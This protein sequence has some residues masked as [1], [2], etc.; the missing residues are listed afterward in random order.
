[1]AGS[2][3]KQKL[4]SQN[5]L[6]RLLRIYSRSLRQNP[7]SIET[8][9]KLAEVLRLLGRQEEAISLYRSVAWAYGLAGNL[10]QAISVCKNILQL[11]PSHDQTQN[12]LAKLYACKEIRQLKRSVHVKQVDGRWVAD[13]SAPKAEPDSQEQIISPPLV[14]S[15]VESPSFRAL[16]PP[17]APSQVKK[18][19]RD[20]GDVEQP[21]SACA[22][23]LDR[24][25]VSSVLRM[26]AARQQQKSLDESSRGYAAI[27]QEVL[28]TG[29]SLEDSDIPSDEAA[30][31]EK[32]LRDTLVDF[33]GDL[34]HEA[35]PLRS[36]AQVEPDQPIPF[37]L[38]SDMDSAAFV[39]L[40]E[41]LE[42]RFYRADSLV[43]AENDPGDS[44]FL[45]SDGS[46]E[47]LKEN[48]DGES[49]IL[50]TLETGAF[51]GEFGLLT[52]Q[53]RHATVRALV[54]TELLELRR[55]VLLELIQ[56]HPSVA[57]TLRLFYQQR[58]MAMVLATSPLFLAVDPAERRTVLSRF[59]VRRFL[60]GETI[61]EMGKVTSG[62]YVILVGEVSVYHMDH[63]GQ[64]VPL[65]VLSEG[66]YFGEMSLLS[67][68]VAGATVKASRLTEVLMLGA[69]DFYELASHHPEIWAEV[70][71]QAKRRQAQTAEI[72]AVD[73]AKK[74]AGPVCLL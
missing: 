40:V 74:A 9:Y 12:M 69:K 14:A 72:L 59:A 60:Q 39:A 71:H 48:D 2:L 61:I 19:T 26:D 56:S 45:I 65:G 41:K 15:I 36:A 42:R 32:D 51:F 22:R 64:D 46:L 47:V 8:R 3:S 31:A 73:A 27:E 17:P 62:F 57:W 52:D 11:N 18:I 58:V 5:Q 6:K 16:D 49:I 21:D 38:F 30:A 29:S 20:Y 50:A 1:M 4:P 43:F 25:I 44:L 68:S 23:P 10:S 66:D 63:R 37:P 55:D 35:P 67:G 54:D 13:P 70:Q 53:R 24:Q 33:P 28:K 34:D 7:K